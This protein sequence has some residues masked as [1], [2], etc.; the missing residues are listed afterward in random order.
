MTTLTNGLG[1]PKKENN[2]IDVN[3]TINKKFVPHLGWSVVNF[4]AFSTVNSNSL[5]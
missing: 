4:L 1:H 3:I 2:I 5:S